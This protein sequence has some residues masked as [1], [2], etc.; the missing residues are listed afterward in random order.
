MWIAEHFFLSNMHRGTKV[1]KRFP[2]FILREGG[3]FL[4]SS[5][6]FYIIAHIAIQSRGVA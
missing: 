5:A 2:F 3:W 6:T 1:H 4:P